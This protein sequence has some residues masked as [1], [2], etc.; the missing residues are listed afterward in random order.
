MRKL[1]LITDPCLFQGKKYLKMSKNYFE[2]WYFKTSNKTSSISFI[3]GVSI[4]GD[5]KNAFIQVITDE[6]SYYV[7]YDINDFSFCDDP[8]LIK[9]G[10][11]YFSDDIIHIDIND[12]NQKL[13]IYGEIKYFDSIN[14]KSSWRSPNIMGIFSYIPSMECNHAIISMRNKANGYICV[15][16]QVF[17]F[18]DSIGY[19]EKDW[20]YSFPKNYVWCQ[21]NNFKDSDSSFMLAIADIPFKFFEF[22]G[23]I[24]SLIVENKEFRFATYNLAKLLN[25]EINNNSLNITLKKGSYTVEIKSNPNLGCRLIAPV[26]GKMQKD[27]I[28]SVLASTSLVLKKKKK[29]IFSDTST[30]CGLEIVSK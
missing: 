23:I 22:R 2:G 21:A 26:D 30:N 9:I 18:I 28:E 19:I 8:F 14:I 29:I 13:A 6:K 16:D 7:N 15:N 1:H 11:N 24:C 4:S 3:P 27:I 17:D 5:N 20:G 10:D 25:F 12:I